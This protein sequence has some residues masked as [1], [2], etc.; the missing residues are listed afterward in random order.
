MASVPDR[1]KSKD[2]LIAEINEL[3]QK[4]TDYMASQSQLAELK[5]NFN[6]FKKRYDALVVDSPESVIIHVDGIIMFIN[7]AGVKLLGFNN[8]KE[9]V[10]ESMFRF[11][12]QDYKDILKQRIHLVQTEHKIIPPQFL[13]LIDDMGNDLY[14]QSW[15]GPIDIQDRTVS[16][17][18]LRDLTKQ[19]LAE[20]AR[21]VLQNK[22]ENAK[23]EWELTADSIPDLICLVDAEGKILRVNRAIETWKLG[24]V[25][26]VKGQLIQ[27]LLH[28][29][30]MGAIKR[31]ETI[32]HRIW[33]NI[34]KIQTMTPGLKDGAY[35]FE[36]YNPCLQ[37]HLLVRLRPLQSETRSVPVDSAVVV[38]E[39]ITEEIK[40]REALASE[41]KRLDVTL[42]SIADGVITT[43]TSG[44]IQL[45][46]R[47][48]EK[49]TGF[50]ESE[51][52]GRQLSEI[53]NVLDEETREH[54]VIPINA[55]IK[56]GKAIQQADHF[57]L[58]AR[59]GREYLI[60]TTVAPLQDIKGKIFG[61]L[62]VF[63]DVTE[64][65]RLERAK[66]SFLNAV[67]HE[68]RTPLTSVSGYTEL[69]LYD[70][71]DGKL[72]TYLE[73]IQVA[74]DKEIAIIDE[75]FLIVQL[76]SGSENYQMSL[77][78]AYSLFLS[79]ANEFEKKVADMI[80]ERYQTDQ[81][82]YNSRISNDLEEV[83]VNVDHR[84]M[85]TIVGVLLSNAVKY[86]P[87]KR[88]VINFSV[89]VEKDRIV[90]SVTDRG[91]GIP[92]SEFTNI[93]KP[94]YQIRYA[95][96][97]VSDGIGYGLTKAKRFI[98]V[99]GGTISI[100][101]ELDEGSR[102]TFTLPIATE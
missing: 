77:V 42:R 85:Q 23:K 92:R 14:V 5:R 64:T 33:K 8:Q 83:L 68:L 76:E 71:P 34:L 98:Q 53:F 36:Y 80:R 93:F 81:Y 45:I 61:L 55:V 86:S 29:N 54:F 97:D 2:Q 10:G 50:T 66:S 32:W 44:N 95:E 30:G 91:K 60:T 40:G 49:M 20:E 67:G 17:I 7:E 59:D 15:G 88:L 70:N 22:I 11:I 28:P 38:I 9:L 21:T 56:T 46:N 74:V 73:D 99:H 58:A 18:V 94:F 1:K 57:I 96:F 51:A 41:K 82:E 4:V 79:I 78:N 12:H 26:K 43:D 102:F 72:K 25:L 52:I 31:F 65:Q 39:D 35:Q 13:R 16:Q 75:L 63:Q 90:V 37:K 100:D 27:R 89:Q 3:R 24:K 87:S 6:D 48:A 101:S 47:I 84:R 62:I 69:L 19:K